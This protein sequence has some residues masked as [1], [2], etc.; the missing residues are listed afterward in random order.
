MANWIEVGEIENF[1]QKE[2]TEITIGKIKLAVSYKDNEFGIISGVCNHVGG[3]LGKGHIDG[4]YVV[5]PWHYWKFH[6]KTGKGEPGFEENKVPSYNFKIENG[7]L[8]VDLDTATKRNKLPHTPHPL[9]RKIQR[10]PGSIRLVGI[11]TTAMNKDY[12]RYSTSN[13]LL[14]T[15]LEYANSMGCETKLFKL[16]EMNIRSCEGYYSQSA[17]ACTF[18]CTITQIDPDDEM[19]KIYEAMVHWGDAFIISTP[20]RWGMPSA[21]YF[22]MVE[23]MNSIQNQETIAG[24]HLLKNKVVGLI[25]TGGQDNVQGV[26]GSMLVFFAEL[27][28]QFPQF[29]FIAHSRGWTAEDME[30]NI[31]FV[32]EN[33]A[34]HD[35]AKAL[36]ERIYEMS[37]LMIGEKALQQKFDK[38]GRK[39][40]NKI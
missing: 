36:V 11:S 5:C 40:S 16:N 27:G 23:R 12:P 29:P 32:K 15:A 9:T 2:L 34:L 24:K 8:F 31:K 1:K 7:K 6:H 17:K 39:A 33:E 35:G 3:P 38:G 19:E 22:K 4:N 26:V 37:S 21:Y 30:N 18:P 13:H 14:N 20:I 10:E 25:V 28:C